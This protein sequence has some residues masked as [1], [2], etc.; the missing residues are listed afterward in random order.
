VQHDCSGCFKLE[1]MCV[2]YYLRLVRQWYHSLQV[3]LANGKHSTVAKAKGCMWKNFLKLA[4]CNAMFQDHYCFDLMYLL[5]NVLFADT[6]CT[7]T[8]KD[9]LMMLITINH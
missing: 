4:T 8:P 5:R 9:C 6:K 2:Q 7:Q 3:K 1:T